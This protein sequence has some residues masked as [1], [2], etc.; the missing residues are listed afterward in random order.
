[1]AV[2]G[3]AV[4]IEND[5][6]KCYFLVKM[7]VHKGFYAY[8]LLNWVNGIW[9]HRQPYT[10]SSGKHHTSHRTSLGANLGCLCPAAPFTPTG[11]LTGAGVGWGS[12]D[13]DLQSH[14]P[15]PSWALPEGLNQRAPGILEAERDGSS[16][17]WASLCFEGRSCSRVRRGEKGPSRPFSESCPTFPGVPTAQ[18]GM[19]LHPLPVGGQ[20]GASYPNLTPAW[21]GIDRGKL[22]SWEGP[23]YLKEFQKPEKMRWIQNAST[24][25]PFPLH[26]SSA[27]RIGF[28]HM[29]MSDPPGKV[30]SIL[31]LLMKA[32]SQRPEGLTGSLRACLPRAGTCLHTLMG[33]SGRRGGGSGFRGGGRRVRHNFAPE[34][35]CSS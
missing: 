30:I 16:A 32:T 6:T 19:P 4:S 24:P 9:G 2:G 31:A 28:S 35:R 22:A 25:R 29:L 27:L 7:G 21:A 11:G 10:W 1:M 14:R 33:G 26:P 23:L 18:V 20:A 3:G 12:R 8:R 34:T 15:T 17:P 13:L 5:F